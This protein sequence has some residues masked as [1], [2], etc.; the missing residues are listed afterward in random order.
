MPLRFRYA[1]RIG[2]GTLFIAWNARLYL[3]LHGGGA[4]S[5][6]VGRQLT[7]V[8]RA[9]DAGAARAAQRHFPEGF[10]F[11]WAFYGLAQA[12]RGL[13]APPGSPV[14]AYALVEVQRALAAV[15]SEE[16]KQPF[17]P[18]LDP[19][20]GAFYMGW[21]TWLRAQAV[22]LA[23]GAAAAP[24]DARR[25]DADAHKIAAAY[26]QAP[27]PFLPTYF[28]EAWPG[29]NVVCIAALRAHDRVLPPAFDATID[30]WLRA[31]RSRTDPRTGLLPHEVSPRTGEMRQGARATSTALLLA[32]LPSLDP[33][34]AR[35]QYR[36]FR[37]LFVVSRFGLPAVL[38]YPQGA[39]GPGDEDSGPLFFGISFSASAMA[40]AA[41]RANGDEPLAEALR[42]A[43]DFIGAT[44]SRPGE[45]Q[46]LLGLVPTADAIIAWAKAMPLPDRIADQAPDA[47]APR[48]LWRLPVHLLSLFLI[49]WPWRRSIAR[50]PR[51]V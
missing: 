28:A 49:A 43:G 4:A 37:S 38:E 14:R 12:E 23:G 35:E 16:G 48:Y 9:L 13:A 34:L 44:P 47:P 21:T 51:H 11:T 29:D 18:E 20:Y 1:A 6:D 10:V 39:T 26:A 33:E 25:L 5:D 19:P 45:K 22:V 15:D 7:F 42:H 32:V 31:I 2:W 36:Q 41:A 24:D 50:W 40:I 30:A 17:E 3:P 46:Y 27:S 8:Q